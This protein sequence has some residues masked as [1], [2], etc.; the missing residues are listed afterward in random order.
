MMLLVLFI[1]QFLRCSRAGEFFVY[2]SLL[3]ERDAAFDLVVHINDKITLNLEKSSVLADELQFVTTSDVG[4]D[5]HLELVDTSA[6]QKTLYHD[7]RHQSS[8]RVRQQGRLVEVEG[9]I[10]S[11]L[12]IKPVPEGERSSHGQLLHKVYEVHE[13]QNGSV[14]TKDMVLQHLRNEDSEEEDHEDFEAQHRVDERNLNGK[15]FTV[16]LHVISDKVHQGSFTKNE[17]LIA[18]TA[19]MANAVNLRY[20]E[21]RHPRV[22]FKLIGITRNRDDSFVRGSQGTIQSDPT[23]DGLGDYYRNGRVPGDPDLVYLL[24]G[25]DMVRTVGGR[26]DKSITGLA[27]LGQVCRSGRVGQGEDTATS[28]SG[29][30]T[31]A[32][33]LAH[34]MGA[35]HDETPKCPWKLGYLMSYIDGGERQYRLSSCSEERIRGALVNLPDRCFDEQSQVNYMSRYRRYP[36]QTVRPEHFCRMI[37]KVSKKNVR[38]IPEKPPHLSTRCK[39]NCCKIVP[40]FGRSCLQVPIPEGM[41]CM[42]GQTCRKGKCG[43]HKW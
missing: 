11:K 3:Q 38:V 25:R 39:M 33:E 34:I 28:Y 40:S 4:D 24:T 2:P 41:E 35:P 37:A 14:L 27:F 32:H 22:Q 26:L 16:E 19:V 43:K 10:N 21:M 36:G 12:R 13:S 29:V 5:D 20:L 7:A 42:K 31:M 30:R 1:L 8:I 18:Y 6:I 9:V 17:E 23:L 15:L